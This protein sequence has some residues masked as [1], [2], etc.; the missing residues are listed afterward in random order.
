M[1]AD[2]DHFR[3]SIE[4]QPDHW[5]LAV[6][7]RVNGARLYHT[8]STNL[9]CAQYVL[10]EFISSELGRRVR[11]D[12]VAWVDVQTSSKP[13]PDDFGVTGLTRLMP[14]AVGRYSGATALGELEVHGILYARI[15]RYC[16]YCEKQSPHEV[17]SGP[18]GTSKVC[19]RCREDELM[20]ELD[21]D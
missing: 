11:N 17:R 10:L 1:H 14:V 19:I 7:N 5:V 4:R 12:D 3:L 18:D 2:V 8:R 20:A 15:L 9:R 16:K 21:P 6:Q 13:V